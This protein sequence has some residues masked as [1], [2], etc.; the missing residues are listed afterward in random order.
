MEKTDPEL[1]CRIIGGLKPPSVEFARWRYDDDD[2][3]D[4]DFNKGCGRK[5][6]FW[7][8]PPLLLML[9]PLPSRPVRGGAFL[10]A[11]GGAP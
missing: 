1:D 2:A 10:D 11:K 9:R 8:P 3:L 7:L 5:T 4:E 6:L